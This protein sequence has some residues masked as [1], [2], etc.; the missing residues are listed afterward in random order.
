MASQ[1]EENADPTPFQIPWGTIEKKMQEPGNALVSLDDQEP[2]PASIEGSLPA[3]DEPKSDLP[4]EAGPIV[5][6]S[7]DPFRPVLDRAQDPQVADASRR[8][9]FAQIHRWLR[10]GNSV[11][12]FC[13]NEGE[14]Q[15]FEEIWEEYGPGPERPSIARIRCPNRKMS[16]TLPRLVSTRQPRARGFLWPEARLVV[17]T[18]SEIFGRY[19]IQR[20]RRLKSPHAAAA[21]SAFE[22][23]FSHLERCPP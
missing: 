13:N 8:E 20:A 7:L 3:G 17:I 2:A 14:R 6:S 18:D 21:R 22:I 11:H 15:R 5:L 19:R 9:F 4:P 23:D 10:Q 12:V 1:A 16:L